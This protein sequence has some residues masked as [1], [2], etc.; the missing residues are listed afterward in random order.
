MKSYHAVFW[1]APYCL[2]PIVSVA[3]VKNQHLQQENWKILEA[4]LRNTEKPEFQQLVSGTGSQKL[5]QNS[6]Q[7]GKVL[8]V[9]H[10]WL[11]SRIPLFLLNC[12]F[13]LHVGKWCTVSWFKLWLYIGKFNLNSLINISIKT[14]PTFKHAKERKQGNYSNPTKIQKKIHLH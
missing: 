8:W 12:Y 9:R 6:H 13:L 5:P 11:S 3:R 14:T 7:P 10:L 1:R 4:D 2:M